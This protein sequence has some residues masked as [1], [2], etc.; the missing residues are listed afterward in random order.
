MIPE[1]EILTSSLNIEARLPPRV[2]KSGENSFINI[3]E[4]ATYN[5]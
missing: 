1:A 4:I 2:L 3:G 5:V